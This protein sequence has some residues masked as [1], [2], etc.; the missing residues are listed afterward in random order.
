VNFNVLIGS[1][2]FSPLSVVL[3][4]IVIVPGIAGVF[5]GLRLKRERPE[6]Y[7]G[8]GFGGAPDTS[9]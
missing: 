8:I 7:G 4:A 6:I 3:P 9:A 1:T 5:W 2:G